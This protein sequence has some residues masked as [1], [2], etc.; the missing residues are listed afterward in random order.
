M[1]IVSNFL[2]KYVWKTFN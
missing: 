2:Q 1:T